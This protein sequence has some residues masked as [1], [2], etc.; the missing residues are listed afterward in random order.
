MILVTPK[1]IDSQNIWQNL[2]WTDRR[3][4]RIEWHW[5]LIEAMNKAKVRKTK[6][7]PGFVRMKI[8][9]YRKVLLDVGNL[10][11]GAKPI[12]D[13]MI[14]LGLLKDDSPKWCDIEYAQ[15]IDKEN[16]RTEIEIF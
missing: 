10:I 16:P 14:K 15:V 12:P 7:A 2:H 9:S 6:V 4:L 11:G 8:T 1:K 5:S 3:K 13:V